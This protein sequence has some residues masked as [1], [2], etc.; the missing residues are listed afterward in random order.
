MVFRDVHG[1]VRRS[2]RVTEQRGRRRARREH[3]Q[4]HRSSLNRDTGQQPEQQTLATGGAP[5]SPV[6]PPP[7]RHDT[8]STVLSFR[9][10][11]GVVSTVFKESVTRRRRHVTWWTERFVFTMGWGSASTTVVPSGPN[12]QRKRP[13][14]RYVEQER[15]LTVSLLLVGCGSLRGGTNRQKAERTERSFELNRLRSYILQKITKT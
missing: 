7:R 8:P 12:T 1:Y 3:Q 14:R 6:F 10:A 5:P 11:R 13:A 4:P 15:I 2:H 9:I